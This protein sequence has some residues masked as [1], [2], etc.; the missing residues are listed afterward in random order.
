MLR[1]VPAG[2]AGE[3]G[4]AAYPAIALHN[5]HCAEHGHNSKSLP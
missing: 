1:H 3:Y 4:L 5:N 2:A